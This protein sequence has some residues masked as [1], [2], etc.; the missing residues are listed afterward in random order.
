MTDPTLLPTQRKVLRA[1]Y[2]LN[3]GHRGY[4]WTVREI[5]RKA[6]LSKV[7][8]ETELDYL[9]DLDLVDAEETITGR[10]ASAAL[11]QEGALLARKVG[12]MVLL[13]GWEVEFKLSFLAIRVRRRA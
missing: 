12:W 10:I 2:K 5:G 3:R 4:E 11:T 1:L 6:G 7:A 8:V 9:A 13:H